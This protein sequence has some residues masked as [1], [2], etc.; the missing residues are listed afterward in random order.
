[1]RFL[2]VGPGA[3]GCLFAARLRIAGNEVMLLDHDQQRAERISHQ[4]ITVTGVSGDYRVPMTAI[5][6]AHPFTPDF[7][8][9]CVKSTNTGEA[10]ESAV[11]FAGQDAEVVTLQN[12]LGNREILEAIFGA[13]KVLGGVTAQGSTLLGEGRI[14]HAGEGET[15]IGPAGREGSAAH[16][17]AASLN[18]AGFET[19]LVGS[20][21]E[22]I[23]GKLIINVGIN[24]LTAVIRVKNG[25]IAAIHGIRT[26]MEDAVSEALQV[27]GAKGIRLPYEEPLERVLA[28]CEATKDNV[29][30]MLQDVL[31]G[32]RTEIEMINGAIVREGERLGIP[33]PVNR[34]LTYLVQGI[35]E[36]YQ[37]RVQ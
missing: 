24:A 34:T 6:G 22:L 23:W 12:G 29:S 35:Q 27:A 2:V 9:I 30:S 18:S 28:V 20:V 3:M 19:R 8:L 36:T 31:K 21:E 4:G 17:L 26:L 14:R 16:A 13:E 7:I 11:S 5:A 1:M 37:D 32:R 10:G 33:T 15:V 25:R